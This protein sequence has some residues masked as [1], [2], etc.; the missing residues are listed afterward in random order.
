MIQKEE[1]IICDSGNDNVGQILSKKVIKQ[2]INLDK[3]GLIGISLRFGTY[4]RKNNSKIKVLITDSLNEKIKHETIVE[5]R[6]LDDGFWKSFPFPD[7]I[8]KNTK[9]IKIEISS[10]ESKI[11]DCVT[12]FYDANSPGKYITIWDR[13]LNGSLNLKLIYKNKYNLDEN[14]KN[15]FLNNN[16]D[17]KINLEKKT[18]KEKLTI[19]CLTYNHEK[20]IE[21]CLVGFLKQKTNF[22]FKIKIIDDGSTDSSI[23]II[24]YYSEKYPEIFEVNFRNF[25]TSPEESFLEL[26]KNIKTDYVALCEGDDFWTSENKLQK[27]FDFLE[28]NKKYSACFHP[29]N[30]EFEN[31]KSKNYIFPKTDKKFFNLNDLIENNYIQ[32]NSIVYRWRF[33]DEDIRKFLPTDSLPGDWYLHL[34]HAEKGNIAYL[35]EIMGVYRKHD[36]GIWSGGVE[37]VVKNYGKEHANFFKNLKNHFQPKYAESLQNRHDFLIKRNKELNKKLKKISVIIPTHNQAD[38]IQYCIE[39]VIKQKGNFDL[40]IIIGNDCST[41]ETLKILNNYKKLNNIKILNHE[42]NLGLLGNLLNCIKECS[43]EY[44]AICEGDDFWT[45]HWRLQRFLNYMENNKEIA[46]AFSHVVLF[47]ENKGYYE[48]PE[49]KKLK[50]K[51]IL[52]EKDLLESNYPGNLSSCFYRKDVLFKVLTNIDNSSDWIINTSV[53]S[54]GGIVFLKEKSSVWRVHSK[55]LWNRYSHSEKIEKI[56]KLKKDLKNILNNFKKKI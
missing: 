47:E 22:N 54:L 36:N 39:S 14:K 30:V 43:G 13:K 25:N 42:Y 56:E 55:G 23:E 3:K 2:E 6:S 10:L 15:N 16:L 52:N 9:K 4:K 41:D 18:T 40:E 12:V 29:V 50:D 32:T 5:C 31:N 17:I 53:S 1:I 49:Q 48:H 46:G 7:Y 37:K 33:K 28:N 8:F 24:K 38:Y 27:Q 21:E 19:C 51:I 45:S 44:V 26:L 35:D 34:L 20:Y 11:N